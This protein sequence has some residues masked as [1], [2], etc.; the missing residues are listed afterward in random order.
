MTRSVW[1]EEVSG[2]F[3]F[4]S[5]FVCVRVSVGFGEEGEGRMMF[6]GERKNSRDHV[7]WVVPGLFTD[8]FWRS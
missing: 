1:S 2:V 8:P 6:V 5:G 7:F 3:N 4:S